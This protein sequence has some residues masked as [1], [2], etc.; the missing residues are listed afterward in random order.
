M[1]FLDLILKSDYKQQ[2]L[3]DLFLSYGAEQTVDLGIV[4]SFGRTSAPL[5]KALLVLCVATAVVPFSVLYTFS[6]AH[7]A[8]SQGFKLQDSKKK[9]CREFLEDVLSIVKSSSYLSG[10]TIVAIFIL[11]YLLTP[12]LGQEFVYLTTSLLG[13]VLLRILYKAGQDP[14]LSTTYCIQGRLRLHPTEEEKRYDEHVLKPAARKHAMEP[15][16]CISCGTNAQCSTRCSVLFSLCIRA[17]DSCCPAKSPTRSIWNFEN[18]LDII[19]LSLNLYQL[20]ALAVVPDVFHD[21]S[22]TR[23]AFE[24]AF[25]DFNFEVS[26]LEVLKLKFWIT[27]A[28]VLVWQALVLLSFFSASTMNFE[29]LTGIPGSKIIINL[30]SNSFNLLIT[31]TLLPWLDC[32]DGSPSMLQVEE[33][34]EDFVNVQC[35]TG[36]HKHYGVWALF[37]LVVYQLS[38]TT[39][40]IRLM[41]DLSFGQDIR[42][43]ETFA[44]KERIFQ[45]AVLC[46]STFSSPTWS[47]ALST[48]LFSLLCYDCLVTPKPHKLRCSC[49]RAECVDSRR[50]I[51][52]RAICYFKGIFYLIFTGASLVSFCAS[53][54]KDPEA[55]WVPFIVLQLLWVSIVVGF[56]FWYCRQK[57]IRLTETEDAPP[58]WFISDS[59]KV[60]VSPDTFVEPTMD[61]SA[62]FASI[63]DSTH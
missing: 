34:I 55:T 40:G 14:Q 9:N 29:Y 24:V 23:A 8:C 53:F 37:L 63:P 1:P 30:L 50:P 16:C 18:K 28:V 27:C 46:V 6:T 36:D 3:L 54:L 33:S 60:R 17:A 38:S 12:K 31:A 4:R 10:W 21:D 52:V 26:H 56:L 13:L 43:R 2:Q 35:W 25:L 7:Q 15:C 19:L 22:P 32:T 62:R 59:V 61:S 41:S 20:A 44:L 47:S 49:G 42:M 48:V 39:V 57:E 11:G 51:N 5:W 45:L 58:D